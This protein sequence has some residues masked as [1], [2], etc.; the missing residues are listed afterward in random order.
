[1]IIEENLKVLNNDVPHIYIFKKISDNIYL[2]S[3]IFL[4]S[5]KFI[6]FQKNLFNEFLWEIIEYLKVENLYIEDFKQ[7]FEEK[8]QEFNTKLSTFAEKLKNIEKIS[9]KGS[10]QIIINDTY[11]NSLI[12]DISTLIFRNNKLIYKVENEEENWKI[13]LFSEMIEWELEDDDLIITLW[14]KISNFLDDKDFEEIIEISKIEEKTILDTLIETLSTRI[15]L[16]EIVYAHSLNIKIPKLEI[17]KE[18]EKRKNLLSFF[19]IK[20]IKNILIDY[21]YPISISLGFIIILIIIRSLINTVT[22]SPSK[23]WN[24]IIIHTDTG[25]MAINC[26]PS[27]IKK[28]IDTFQKIPT[29]SPQ[30]TKTYNKI[31][32]QI[33][34]CKKENLYIDELN[35]LQK[36]LTKS[37]YAAFN[38]FIIDSWN[39]NKIASIPENTINKLGKIIYLKK[40]NSFFIWGTSG[41]IIWLINQQIPW[42]F[43][44]LNNLTNIKGYITNLI[45]NWLYVRTNKNIYNITKWGIDN[46]TATNWFPKNIGLLFKY[47]KI[48]KLYI[49]SE[50]PKDINEWK[51]IY[52]YENIIGS[53]TRFKWPVSIYIL[54][55]DLLK[56]LKAN[57][58]SGF[59]DIKIDT[60]NWSILAWSKKDHSLYQF[61]RPIP[62]KKILNARIIPLLSNPPGLERL[63]E[64]V[65]IFVFGTKSLYWNRIYLFDANKKQ[66]IIYKSIWRKSNDA[67]RYTY[68]LIYELSIDLN[69]LDIASVDVKLERKPIL[70]VLTKDWNIYQLNLWLFIDSLQK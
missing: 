2:V 41:A 23:T 11:L 45:G 29:D 49:N 13:D 47:G 9:I 36:I 52:K 42:K 14:T 38:I 3:T 59:S 28:Q 46:V 60:I 7:F 69:N 65:K 30:K 56:K 24:E 53:Q 54:K 57:F 16:K 4:L 26:L 64:N 18:L 8:L 62:T 66:L 17:K 61:R 39:N 44:N 12:W 58:L 34:L 67:N 50:N 22:N 33:Q 51:L 55:S 15:D 31:L 25:T 48:N 68:K 63:S 32:Q 6:E 70:Y 5:D 20:R 43:I 35:Q 37:Y 19:S 1:M 10:I 40:S 27:D 21:K